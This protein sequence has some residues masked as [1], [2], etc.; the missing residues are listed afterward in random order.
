M[1]SLLPWSYS[2]WVNTNSAFYINSIVGCQHFTI[3]RS[4]YCRCSVTKLCPTLCNPRD[5]GP[6][7]FSIHGILQAKILEWVSIPFSRIF[8]T[9]GSN[10]H[11]WHCQSHI[12]FQDSPQPKLN[13]CKLFFFWVSGAVDTNSIFLM[14]L[15]HWQAV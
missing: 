2:V 12:H 13:L 3:K 9:Q 8:P 15:N 7:G 11:L 14:L 4:I 1:A 10:L 6:S 5:C